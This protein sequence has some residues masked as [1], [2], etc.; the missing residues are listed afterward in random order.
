MSAHDN[1]PQCHGDQSNRRAPNDCDGCGG[2]GRVCPV[3]E[4]K[5][6]ETCRC[7]RSDSICENGHKWHFCL[8][9]KNAV[10]GETSHDLNSCSCRPRESLTE[11]IARL[12]T[13]DPD[14][15][16]DPHETWQKN[17]KP[18]GKHSE[19]GWA[20]PVGEDGADEE[21]EDLVHGQKHD[22]EVPFDDSQDN[23]I[24]HTHP[25]T[26]DGP[27]PIRALPSVADL[28]VI[29][30]KGVTGIGIYND[31]WLAKITPKNELTTLGPTGR[32]EQI[33]R[34]SDN[35]PETLHNACAALGRLGF[36][37]EI[38]DSRDGTVVEH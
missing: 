10:I 37:V 23:I 3:C 15:F 28:K 33:L 5:V 24:Y 14:V 31:Y 12:I 27:T 9:H 38:T 35:S 21:A 29:L 32:Y 4:G 8:Q 34:Q 11:S 6:T 18:E 17:V 1:C 13:E 20:A 25:V 30:K 7:F 19:I 22:V 16:A 2:Y 36:D 26:G